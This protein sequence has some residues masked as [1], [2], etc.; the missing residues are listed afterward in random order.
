M[1]INKPEPLE[2]EIECNTEQIDD[3]IK[4]ADELAEA[5]ELPKLVIRSCRNCTFNI[6]I[7]GQS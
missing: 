7:G 3:A 4:K 2:I 5:L 1:T 6:T